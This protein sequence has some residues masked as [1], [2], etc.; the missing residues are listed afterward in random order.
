MGRHVLIY[1]MNETLDRSSGDSRA[2]CCPYHKVKSAIGVSD[3]G[4]CN[5]RKWSLAG[6]DIVAGLGDVAKCIID[7]GNTEIC[8]N[9]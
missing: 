3:N 8:S 6:L 2:T 7:I 1:S 9:C 4:R 5:G